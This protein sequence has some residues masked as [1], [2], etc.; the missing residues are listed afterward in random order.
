MEPP[1]HDQ[2]QHE[3]HGGADQAPAQFLQVLPQG[4]ARILQP[5][6][7]TLVGLGRHAGLAEIRTGGAR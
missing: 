1:G 6:S 7:L 5:R 3:G 4:H 2:G